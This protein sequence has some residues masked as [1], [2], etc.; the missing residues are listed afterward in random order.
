[1]RDILTIVFLTVFISAATIVIS[2]RHVKSKLK[3]E[4]ERWELER[5]DYIQLHR[6]D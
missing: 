2:Y 3:E 5:P 1:M 6:R 4:E